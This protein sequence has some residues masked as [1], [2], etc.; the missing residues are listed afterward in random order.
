M[1]KL[2]SF[3]GPGTAGL[4]QRISREGE[5][6]KAMPYNASEEKLS[7]VEYNRVLECDHNQ[8]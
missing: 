5:K 2:E 7:V 6:D 1:E 8:Y 3:V 4:T